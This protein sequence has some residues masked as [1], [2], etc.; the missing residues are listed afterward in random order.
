M[1]VP[2][3]K[4]SESMHLWKPIALIVVPSMLVFG[5]CIVDN[6][7]SSFEQVEILHRT[8]AVRMISIAPNAADPN[9]IKAARLHPAGVFIGS[10]I[11]P[12]GLHGR[13][14]KPAY[15]PGLPK[16]QCFIATGQ[17]RAFPEQR[18]ASG[19]MPYNAIGVLILVLIP[20]SAAIIM[21]VN[22][23]RL[24]AADLGSHRQAE[25]ER[26]SGK[27]KVEAILENAE[28]VVRMLAS[29]VRH[30][31]E[32]VSIAEMDGKM[33]FLNGTA[34][35]MLGIDPEEV[36]TINIRQIM[37]DHMKG[38]LERE[39]L[40]EIEAGRSWEGELQYVNLKSGAVMNAHTLMFTIDDP[41]DGYHTYLVNVSLD[42]SLHKQA[43]EKFT[44][45]FMLAPDGISIT[46]MSD[47]LIVDTN[48]GFQ[49]ISGWKRGEVLGRTSLEVNFWADPAD[50]ALLVEELKAGRDVLHHDFQFRRK[51]G[52][53]RSG[54][55]SA[56]PIQIDGEECLVFVMQDI[57][58]R[59]ETER[60]LRQSE[61]RLRAITTNIPGVVYQFFAKDSGGFSTTYTSDAIQEIFGLPVEGTT[62]YRTFLKHIHEED[63]ERFVTSIQTA[64]RNRTPWN[65]EGRFVKPSGET[66]WFQGLSTPTRH[67]DGL[68]FDGIMLNITERKLAEEQSLQAQD[69][70]AKVFMTT[71][72]CIAITRMHD[73]MIMDVNRGFEDVLGWRREEVL[74]RTTLG[75]NIWGDEAER[76]QMVD[77]LN[78]G[79]DVLHRESEFRHRDGTLLSVS[80]SARSIQ[81][82]GE[83]CIICVL[84]DMSDRRRLEEDRRKLEQQL[85]QSQKM[86]AIGHLASG[87]AHDF[88]NILTGIQGNASLM[89][90]DYDPEHPHYQRLSQIEEQV[91]RGAN[92]TRQLL[93]F[94]RGGKYEV[95][96]VAIND[97]IRKTAQ[98][99]L[100]TR[101]EIEVNFSLGDDVSPV[102]A[103]A[104]QIE[105]VLLNLFINAG[106]AMP[107][108]GVLHIQTANVMLTQAEAKAFEIPPGEY[109]KISVSDT[110]I[111]MDQ[112]TLM[113]IFEPFF[114]TRSQQGGTG[115]GLASSYGIIR[116]HGGAIHA[117]SE[118]GNGSTFSILLPSSPNRIEKENHAAYKGLRS[119][120]GSILLVDDES[121]I[122]DTASNLLNILGYT[123]FQAASGQ[124]A[125]DTYREMH[126]RI[127]LI[128]L[129]MIMPGMSG[130]QTLETLKMIDP[131][132]KV[133]LSSGYGL[134]GEVRKVLGTGC[135]GFI[136]KPY[137]ISELAAIVHQV[138]YPKD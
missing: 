91:R 63:R 114:T 15:A 54:I 79:R 11:D 35:K 100:E 66:I 126:E 65:F 75:I 40:P 94:A 106:H 48:L 9:M 42:I 12:P 121:T 56:R 10:R 115:L 67:D 109:I 72:D 69:K 83:S 118:P 133:I 55:Y 14:E 104:G 108:G 1:E 7:Y 68:I 96:T 131:E 31:R 62:M 6:Q 58:R 73:G 18:K 112:E 92:L 34:S 138:L 36:E 85:F 47:G 74:G 26:K 37:P 4:R 78:A 122:L 81:I 111:G 46:R 124:E 39:V 41:K 23:N 27:A 103:D 49:E 21:L 52:T 33:I 113:R 90:L 50:R 71:P 80:F 70:F 77:D 119:G 98:F 99:F 44:K 120:S 88:N 28:E 20:V 53:L 59:K 17:Y 19:G 136:Q 89:M 61:E 86:D 13:R 76:V 132:V 110:G 97:L 57:S 43:E 45:V 105:Q 117:Y 135:R 16:I 129:D 102:D 60:L 87:V 125:V 38:V 25:D 3:R 51:D 123:V 134:Q 30:S 93:G 2:E 130:S 95:K 24:L 29:V 127:D 116:N 137:L 8:S 5:F 22:R 84:Q 32:L 107:G 64:I 128:I 82:A 101:R